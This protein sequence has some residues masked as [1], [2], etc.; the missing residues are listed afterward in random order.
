MIHL[1]T[2]V[3]VW[4][5]TERV[6]RLTTTA[7]RL[8]EREEVGYSPMVVLEL[9][10]LHEVGRLTDQ[11]EAVLAALTPA[12]QLQQSTAPFASVVARAQQLTWTRD[13]FDRLIAANAA[14]DGA[15]LV[16]ADQSMLRSVP[17]AAWE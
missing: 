11:P 14:V 17:D 15:M 5:Y 3:V 9:A 10:Y 6:G 13:P 4:L 1:D 2:H 7:R 8:I 16:T 12:L